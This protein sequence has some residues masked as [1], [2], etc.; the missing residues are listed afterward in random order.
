MAKEKAG[1]ATAAVFIQQATLVDGAQGVVDA[2]AA[3]LQAESWTIVD[4]KADISGAMQAA[5]TKQM[6]A[7]GVTDEQSANVVIAASVTLPYATMNATAEQAMKRYLDSNE[8]QNIRVTGKVC[9]DT[10]TFTGDASVSATY[11]SASG[12]GSV[13]HA[14]QNP[15]VRNTQ[16]ALQAHLDTVRAA[17]AAKAPKQ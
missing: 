15:L 8:Q 3:E 16:S 1:A 11:A 2:V 13:S 7:I 9:G 5:W 17:D 14:V 12:S 10:L 4:G 6:N